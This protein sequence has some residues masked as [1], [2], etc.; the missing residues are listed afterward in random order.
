MYLL[1][2]DIIDIFKNQIYAHV[3]QTFRIKCVQSERE[4]ECHMLSNNILK[5]VCFS[6]ITLYGHARNLDTK[7]LHVATEVGNHLFSSYEYIYI[8]III[9]II[10]IYYL[11]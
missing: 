2:C 3:A 10:I 8:Y 9:I 6:D 5:F 4:S 1:Q 7:T 11:R